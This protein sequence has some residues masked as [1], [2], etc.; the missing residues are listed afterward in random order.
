MSSE[1][2]K[3]ELQHLG[4]PEISSETV[5]QMPKDKTCSFY[6]SKQILIV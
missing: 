2:L 3:T 5:S 4:E 6:I 1:L